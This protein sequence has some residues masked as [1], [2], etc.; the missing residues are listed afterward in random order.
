MK[1]SA[2]EDGAPRWL[3]FDAMRNQY[4]AISQDAFSLVRHWQ[5]GLDAANFTKVLREKGL[6]FSADEVASFIEFLIQN[7][8]VMARDENLSARLNE[9]YKKRRVGFWRWLIHN[10]LF[11]RIPLLKPDGWL[12]RWAP[13]LEWVTAPFWHWAVLLLGTLGCVLVLRQWDSFQS[14]FMHFFSIEGML[15]YGLTLALVK[16]AHELGHAFVAKWQG[17]RVASMGVAFLVMFPVLYTDTTDA[18]RLQ[19]RYKRLKIVTAGV[20]VEIYL[21]MLATFCWSFLP[22]GPLRSAAFF[23]ATTSWVTSLLVNISPFLRFDGYYAFSDWL[24]IENLQSR[25]FEMGRWS[26]RRILFGFEDPLPEPLPKRRCRTMII[27]AWCTW[28]YRFFLFLGIALVVYHLFF[29]LLGIL[30]FIVEILW[31]ILFPMFRELKVWYRRRQDVRV[32]PARILALLVTGT[33][34]LWLVLPLPTHVKIPAIFKAGQFTE[35]HSPVP[36]RV[37]ER[38]VVPGEVV[39]S[40]QLLVRLTSDKLDYQ[41][42]LLEEELRLI[43]LR[44]QRRASSREEKVNLAI[45]TRQEEQVNKQLAGVLQRQKQLEIRATHGGIVSS[46]SVA[47]VGS[48]VGV[49]EVLVSVVDLSSSGLEGYLSES[50]L[51]VVRDGQQGVFIS[52]LGGDAVP[53]A[54]VGIDIAAMQHVQYEEL[55]SSQGGRIAVRRL[56]N[57][58]LVPEQSYYPVRFTDVSDLSTPNSWRVPGVVVLEA[59]SRSLILYGLQKLGMVLLRESGF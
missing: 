52:D 16:S 10:Y 37:G 6:E 53:V 55:A 50:E 22:D 18:W 33:L 48:W 8:L 20:R 41:Q 28:I 17:C 26:L 45:L 36:V 32:D 4:F 43:Q 14:T 30:L 25:A 11:I 29:K 59:E 12:N 27:Y 42:T 47:G 1:A 44:K 31:F 15:L 51:D 46:V 58:S 54:L 7:N 3:L 40:G 5:P 2:D 24:G 34:L 35:F 56:P 38:L 57:G 13:R 21:A 39:E 49:K 19:S 23:I 9:E